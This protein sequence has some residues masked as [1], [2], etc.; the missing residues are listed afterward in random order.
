MAGLPA[1]HGRWAE[2]RNVSRGGEDV[3]ESWLGAVQPAAVC[4]TDRLLLLLVLQLLLLEASWVVSGVECGV[5]VVR[6]QLFSTC[7]MHRC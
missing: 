3:G 4:N 7:Q 6:H 1:V 2:S 5:P